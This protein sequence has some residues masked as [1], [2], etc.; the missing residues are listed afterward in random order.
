MSMQSDL[1][2]FMKRCIGYLSLTSELIER[3]GD[4]INVGE[5]FVLRFTLKN[6]L[7][8]GQDPDIAFIGAMA[9][10]HAAFT[11]PVG[12][13]S[14]PLETP[15]G[16]ALVLRRAFFR[17]RVEH[18]VV[19]YKGG[20]AADPTVTRTKEAAKARAEEA[21]AKFEADPAAWKK[22]VAEYSEEP[23]AGER[24]GSLGIAEP[25]KFVPAFDEAIANLK[26]GEHTKVFETPFGYHVARRVP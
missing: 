13:V 19:L 22:I 7:V 21:L 23:G 1:D 3:A 18:L 20:A 16:Y 2:R 11:L 5:T 9:A 6:E 24:S 10:Q 4:R 15:V 12:D 25:G 8:A 17:M 14:A 26:V